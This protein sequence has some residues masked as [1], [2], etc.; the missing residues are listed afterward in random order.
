MRASTG[1][2]D[3]HNPAPAFQPAVGRS[4]NLNFD[5]YYGDIPFTAVIGGTSYIDRFR[6]FAQMEIGLAADDGNIV[7]RKCQGNDHVFG[8][9]PDLYNYFIAGSGTSFTARKG[10]AIIA[11]D[12]PIQNVIN[13]IRTDANRNDVTIQFGNGITN[14]NIGTAS[15]RFNGNWG[16]VTLTGGITGTNA[17]A[18]EGIIVIE[19]NVSM[20]YRATMVHNGTGTNTRGVYHNST[21]TFTMSA[22]TLIAPGNAIR[23]V[24]NGTVNISGGTISGTTMSGIAIFNQSSGNITITGDAIVTSPNDNSFFGTIVN[25]AGGSI[26][27]NGG[28]QIRNTAN[29][30]SSRTIYNISGGTVTISDGL[31]T[32]VGLGTAIRNDHAN[33][34][35]TITGGRVG[36]RATASTNVLSE[37]DGFALRQEAGT[38]TVGGTAEIVG[39]VF[40]EDLLD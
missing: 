17:I 3:T 37:T 20:H 2:G 12:Q 39:R 1:S 19:D 16:L 23:N 9:D 35:I 26:N 33:G 36:T 18:N 13:A 34:T 32:A 28:D 5:N 15:L 29:S 22:G 31:V 11:E 7:A 24:R 21:G 30:A 38:I 27:I 8:C 25:N 4:Y 10:C 40:P 14:L 6:L